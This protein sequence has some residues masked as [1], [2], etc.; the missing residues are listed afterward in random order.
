MYLNNPQ[1]ISPLDVINKIS[2]FHAITEARA[3]LEFRELVKEGFI[4]RENFDSEQGL[5]V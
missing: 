3:H 2:P 5:G 4:V 1:K